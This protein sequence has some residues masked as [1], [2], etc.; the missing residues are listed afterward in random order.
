M[1][2]IV[3]PSRDRALR[4]FESLAA[5][6]LLAERGRLAK[7]TGSARLSLR[8]VFEASNLSAH[9]FADEVA[10]NFELRRAS[11]AE[12]TSAEALGAGFSERFL[13]EAAIFPFAD[14]DGRI[15]VAM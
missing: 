13:R 6:G 3:A 14:G 12:L 8:A 15:R 5:R 9:D 4:V 11:L 10:E 7:A 2:A 1:S